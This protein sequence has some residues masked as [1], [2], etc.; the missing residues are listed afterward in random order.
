MLPAMSST[1]R[2]DLALK[3]DGAGLGRRR[4]ALASDVHHRR[5]DASCVVTEGRTSAIG[6]D[7]MTRSDVLA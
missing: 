4:V 1:S 6:F 7:D 3:C 2:R 5:S